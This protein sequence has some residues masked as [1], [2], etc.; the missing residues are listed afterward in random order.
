MNTHPSR[1]VCLSPETSETLCLLGE[2]Q[3]IVGFSGSPARLPAEIHAKPRVSVQTTTCVDRICAL[4]PDLVLGFGE[5]HGDVLGG[6]AQRG[7]SVHLFNQRSVRGILDMIRIVGGVVGRDAE[8]AHFA[9]TLEWRIEAIR[10]RSV[11]ERRPRIYFEEWDEPSITA[12]SWVSELITIAGGDNCFPELAHQRR[13]E[14]RVVHDSDEVV[15]RAPDIIVAAWN[16]KAFDRESVLHRNGWADVPAV[17]NGEIHAIPSSLI[18]Q[19]GPAALT[20]GLDALHA[21]VEGW[22]EHRTRMFQTAFG[23]GNAEQ[24]AGRE[25]VA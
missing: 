6:L 25:R 18:L 21:I 3:R 1:I 5:S 8:A 7:V 9:A 14:G 13:P 11:H 12:T 19:P 2:A 16:G 24:S 17:W 15:R 22:R 20:D 4:E 10:A 23:S